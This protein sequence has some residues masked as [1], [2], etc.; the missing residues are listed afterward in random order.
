MPLCPIMGIS[1]RAYIPQNIGNCET[2]F[3]KVPVVQNRQSPQG[4]LSLH[5][6]SQRCI[7]RQNT[8][9]KHRRR[10]STLLAI[11]L[12]RTTAI[13]ESCVSQ[14]P[15]DDTIS[16]DIRNRVFV[17]W[18]VACTYCSTDNGWTVAGSWERCGYGKRGGGVVEYG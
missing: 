4:T 9:S 16:A 14:L 13:L 8:A 2:L 17:K 18:Y 6:R 10:H 3:S 7:R 1:Q 5:C 12:F 11:C 15:N